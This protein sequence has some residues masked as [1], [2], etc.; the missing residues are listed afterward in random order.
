MGCESNH[1]FRSRKDSF[2]ISDAGNRPEHA[3]A[4]GRNRLGLEFDGLSG[5]FEVSMIRCSA[6]RH[7]PVVAMGDSTA[8]H[9][10]DRRDAPQP[11]CCQ[12]LQPGNAALLTLLQ[13]APP[14]MV[15]IWPSLRVASASSGDATSF[16]KAPGSLL[17][18]GS[19]GLVPVIKP[20]SFHR[21]RRA[22]HI[23]GGE[24]PLFHPRQRKAC[25]WS[26]WIVPTRNR[27]RRQ[28]LLFRW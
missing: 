5:T 17:S 1:G 3:V 8:D 21:F 27:F 9:P 12:G 16:T 14:A 19:T 4:V 26:S 22:D 6:I 7:L 13:S 10:S 25:H 23:C 11:G 24:K 15:S 18:T 20:I 28:R 2:V